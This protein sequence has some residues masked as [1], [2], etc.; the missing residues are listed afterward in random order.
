MPRKTWKELKAGV[1]PET[2]RR[3]EAKAQMFLAGLHLDELR[4]HVGLTQEQL[5]SRLGTVQPT[6]SKLER[7]SD[8]LVSTLRDVVEAMGGAL[9]VTARFGTDAFRLSQ[10]SSDAALQQPT[11]GFV[12]LGEAAQPSRIGLNLYWAGPVTVLGKIP[13]HAE[14]GFVAESI[15]RVPV[16]RLPDGVEQAANDDVALAA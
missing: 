9:D 11:S 15:N 4:K 14:A 1:A 3:G 5:A 12:E 13:P 2:R 16:P 10:Y 8:L 7:R 6:V